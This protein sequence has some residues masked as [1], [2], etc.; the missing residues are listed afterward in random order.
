LQHWV[1]HTPYLE[2]VRLGFFGDT[3]SADWLHGLLL[4]LV[5]VGAVKRDGDWVV[6]A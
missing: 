5:R 4:E 3:P 6:D 1:A 2:T